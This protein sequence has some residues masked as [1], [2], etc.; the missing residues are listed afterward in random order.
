MIIN[1]ITNKINKKFYI[2]KTV[3]SAKERFRAHKYNHKK[4][5]TYLYHSMRKHG[6][7]NFSIEIVEEV[8]GNIDEREKY[9][10]Q[11]LKPHYNMTEGGDGGDTSNSP[12][13]IKGM[14]KRDISG[15]KNGM[16][17]KSRPDTAKYLAAAKDKMISSN[18]CPVVCEG[19]TF[20]SVGDA[21]AAYPGI[22]LR[23]RLDSAK[24]PEFYR[25]RP[26][27]QRYTSQK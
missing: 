14:E 8:K 20:K 23:N 22:K 13:Y 9:W 10:I 24:Y 2:G 4:Q 5:N 18:R 12:N 21:E 17:G 27:T 26:K 3:K 7:D 6:I 11:K 16:Y 1:Q 15:K 25:L 19:I